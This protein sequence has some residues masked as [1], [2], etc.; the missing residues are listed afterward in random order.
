LKRGCSGACCVS[1]C[2]E[3]AT[4]E[5]KE[6]VKCVHA[7]VLCCCRRLVCFLFFPTT[8][9]ERAACV[10]PTER[11]IVRG[12]VVARVCEHN[13]KMEREKIFKERT[14]MI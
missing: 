7:C 9:S 3:C 10:A 4:S 1:V 12:G 2:A 11:E 14:K 8:E 6:S 5:R 13:M